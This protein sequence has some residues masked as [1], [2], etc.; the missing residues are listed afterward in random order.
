MGALRFLLWTGLC[1]GA[2]IALATVDVAGRTPLSH[3]ERAWRHHGPRLEREVKEAS[4]EVV[5]EVKKKV[6]QTPAEPRESHGKADR[7]AV[8][9]II[10]R[11]RPAP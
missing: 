10:A 4:A 7:D 8:A 9:D 6:G 3:L 11:R 2:G 5:D 1:M